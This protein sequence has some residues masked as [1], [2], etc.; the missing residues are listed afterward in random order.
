[1]RENAIETDKLADGHGNLSF[2]FASVYLKLVCSAVSLRSASVSRFW[3]HHKTAFRSG[4]AETRNVKPET[5]FG[6][7]RNFIPRIPQRHAI[8]WT[9]SW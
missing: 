7:A 2:W 9:F 4:N 5:A 1:M 6:D 3:F 8:P